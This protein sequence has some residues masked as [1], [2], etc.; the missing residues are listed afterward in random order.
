[1]TTTGTHPAG[2]VHT[3]TATAAIDARPTAGTDPTT[4]TGNRPDKSTSPS[5]A[6]SPAVTGTAHRH[7]RPSQRPS[8]RYT[9]ST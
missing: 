3:N 2:S 9:N 4:G 1:M 5:R 8:H 6:R 7:V